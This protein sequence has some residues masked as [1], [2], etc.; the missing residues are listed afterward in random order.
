MFILEHKPYAQLTSRPFY[1]TL[2]NLFMKHPQPRSLTSR[3]KTLP[4]GVLSP[5]IPQGLL[6]S[7]LCHLAC[8]SAPKFEKSYAQAT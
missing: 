4:P 3:S 6:S 1:F 5:S 2:W 8:G 7:A